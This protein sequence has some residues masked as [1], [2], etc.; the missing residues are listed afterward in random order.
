MTTRGGQASKK[1]IQGLGKSHG[2]S[3]NGANKQGIKNDYNYYLGSAMKASD[4]EMTTEYI[5]S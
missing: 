2:M 5:I 3:H 1:V 4:Y